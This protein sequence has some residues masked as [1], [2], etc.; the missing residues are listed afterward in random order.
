MITGLGSLGLARGM[1]LGVPQ[2]GQITHWP[3]A[4]ADVV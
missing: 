3:M 2:E 1:Y 4:Y